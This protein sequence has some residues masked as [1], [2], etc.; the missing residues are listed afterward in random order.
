MI[1]R[2]SLLLLSGIVGLLGWSTAPAQTTGQVYEITVQAS[3]VY[4]EPSAVDTNEDVLVRGMFN[5]AVI[6]NAARGRN[7]AAQVPANEKLALVLVFGDDVRTA[8][9]LIVY[10]TNGRSN[11]VTICELVVFGAFDTVKDAGFIAM[12]GEIGRAGALRGG[13]LALSG[14]A[15]V[16]ET[17]PT[18]PALAFKG[19]AV[20]GMVRG[21]NDDELIITK[22][23]FATVGRLGTLVIPAV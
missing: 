20:Q 8:G 10:D 2:V 5:S 23:R 15:R 9:A 11:L 6:I 3:Y 1:F 12:V 17:I 16:E 18:A 4:S 21:D 19:N 7:I 22:G 14:K 13:W